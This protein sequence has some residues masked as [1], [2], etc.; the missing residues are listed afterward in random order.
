MFA[1]VEGL[2]ACC[3]SFF[4]PWFGLVPGLTR[5]DFLLVLTVESY[6]E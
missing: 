2:M 5:L 6:T 4:G 1:S 3:F